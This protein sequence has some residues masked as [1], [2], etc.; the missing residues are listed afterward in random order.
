MNITINRTVDLTAPILPEVLSAPLYQDE[1]NAHTFVIEAT[2]NKVPLPI[3]G[4]VTAYFVRGDGNTVPLEGEIVNAMAKVTLS[5]SCYYTG[6]FHMAV[7]LI[8]QEA[9][10]VIYAAS[11]RVKGI[12]NGEIIDGGENEENGTPGIAGKDGATFFPYVDENGNLSWTND[13]DLP[14]PPT[15]NIKGGPGYTPQKGVDYWTKEDQKSMIEDVLAAIPVYD[16]TYEIT[17]KVDGQT[18]N[19]KQKYMKNDVSI[20][21]IPYF[22]TGNEAGGETVYI[23]TEVEIYGE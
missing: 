5:K 1:K 14:N 7:M 21:E 4:S 22:E 10:T 12:K 19:T 16:G 18:I 23:G 13:K 15:V 11:G 8:T 20:K 2:R 6:A 3:E 9:R 17:P